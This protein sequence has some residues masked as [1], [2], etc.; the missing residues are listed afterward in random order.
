MRQHLVGD[1]LEEQRRNQG[2]ELQEER[3]D[4]HFAEQPAVFVHRLE[5]PGDIKLARQIR[6][7]G[8]PRHQHDAAGPVLLELRALDDLRT[9]DRWVVNEDIVDSGL[10]KDNE[11]AVLP[12]DDC[13]Q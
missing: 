11:T 12:F 8:A 7:R 2:E 13:R 3:G 4:Q 6:E 10:A 9:I 1:D 5:E